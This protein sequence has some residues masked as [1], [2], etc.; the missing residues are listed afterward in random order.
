MYD[1]KLRDKARA[2][3][4]REVL[5]KYK[6]EKGCVDCGYNKNPLALEFDHLPGT[7]KRKNV[8]ALLYNSW[9]IIWEEVAKCEV[10][11]ANC[12]AIR[13]FTRMGL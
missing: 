5:A 3:E 12:H 9:K 1:A 11:C 8:A 7:T 10:V 13:T 4:K 2:S 6:V